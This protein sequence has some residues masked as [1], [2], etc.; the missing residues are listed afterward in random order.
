M[1]GGLGAKR[2]VLR[3]AP[4]LGIDDGAEL[5]PLAIVVI[6]NPTGAMEEEGDKGIFHPQE[7][8]GRG[9]GQPTIIQSLLNALFDELMHGDDT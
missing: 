3:T 1:M 8:L 7:V 5:Y 2:T 6:P 4:G 9:C